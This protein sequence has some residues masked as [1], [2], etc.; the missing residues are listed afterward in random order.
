MAVRGC[1]V[2]VGD[3]E[4][5]RSRVND[6]LHSELREKRSGSVS[7]RPLCD[8]DVGAADERPSKSV[9]FQFDNAGGRLSSSGCELVVCQMLGS[10]SRVV[11][12]R[13]LLI[14][15]HLNWKLMHESELA[16]RVGRGSMKL[17]E[18]VYRFL[19]ELQ[20]SMVWILGAQ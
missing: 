18:W 8:V 15:V 7:K 19:R 16:M 20:D 11:A 3:K 9:A 14:M 13:M 6:F 1:N 10:H 12:Y 17:R 4:M 5:L 2:V